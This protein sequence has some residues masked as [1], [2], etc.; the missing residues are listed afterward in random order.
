MTCKKKDKNNVREIILQNTLF[1]TTQ[2]PMQRQPQSYTLR[3]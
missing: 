2:I 3:G 1:V